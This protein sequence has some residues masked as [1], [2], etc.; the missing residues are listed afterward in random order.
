LTRE[1]GEIIG[2]GKKEKFQWNT[3]NFAPPPP[4]GDSLIHFNIFRTSVKIYLTDL[5]HERLGPG[6]K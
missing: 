1:H 2:E 5:A 4:L 6:Y 3:G